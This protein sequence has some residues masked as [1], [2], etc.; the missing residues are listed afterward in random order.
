MGAALERLADWIKRTLRRFYG[1]V[2]DAND[3]G[4]QRANPRDF[5][6]L[7]I[8]RCLASPTRGSP[9]KA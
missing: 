2:A 9:Q 4:V 1:G 5:L 6:G 8:E 7:A 3:R